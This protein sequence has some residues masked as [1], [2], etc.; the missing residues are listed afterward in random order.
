MSG[1]S[2][3]RVKVTLRNPIDKTKTITYTI[4][5][6]S[7]RLAQDWIVAL[8]QLLQQQNHLEKNYCFLGFPN[9]ARNLDYLCNELNR[10]V[11]TINQFN[12]T[13]AWV[14]AGLESYF[15]EEYFCPNSVRFD[16]SYAVGDPNWLKIG[17][18]VKHK[19][20]NQLHNH[21]ERLQGTVWNLSDY[22]QLADLDTKYAIR[23]LNNLCHEIENIILSQRKFAF[24]PQWVRPSQIT[25]FLHAPRFELTD[26]HRQGFL[27]NG[28]NR[29][30]GGVYMHWAQIGKTLF[31]VWR[32]EGAPQLNIGSDPTD[33]SVGAGTTCEAINSLKYYS[34]EFDVE[35]ANSVTDSPLYPWHVEQQSEYQQWLISNGIDITNPELSLGY[36][37]IGQVDFDS[38]FNTSNYQEIWHTLGQHLDIYCI[39]VDGISCTYNYCWSDIDHEAQQK[40]TL[41]KAE[42]VLD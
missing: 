23:Q 14:N 12:A 29:E 6:E 36:L 13:G 4:I 11:M 41:K 32:D 8:K 21:F 28:Y 3:S 39:E 5:P 9:S 20:L 35:W 18:T 10:H 38:S 16:E 24:D 19:I 25:T 34:G 40:Q 2:Q 22:Y 17:L 7:T 30:F 26:E 42:N 27:T 33:I 15:I 1:T 31:E 37:K